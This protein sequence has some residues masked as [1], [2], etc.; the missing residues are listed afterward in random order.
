MSKKYKTLEEASAATIALFK[1]HGI[2]KL[3]PPYT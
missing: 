1:K 2:E 3:L